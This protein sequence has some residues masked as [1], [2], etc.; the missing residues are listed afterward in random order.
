LISSCITPVASSISYRGSGR[1]P[2]FFFSA[3]SCWSARRSSRFATPAVSVG[4]RRPHTLRDRAV[5]RYPELD[6]CANVYRSGSA[7]LTGSWADSNWS[8]PY[9][10][11][12]EY[13]IWLRASDSGLIDPK[14][15][16]LTPFDVHWDLYH[17]EKVVSSSL[18]ATLIITSLTAVPTQEPL[19]APS[20]LIPSSPSADLSRLLFSGG[21]RVTGRLG[22]MSRQ[23]LCRG[24]RTNGRAART[25]AR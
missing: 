5:Y 3:S 18:Q 12:G 2:H 6:G 11:R 25:S 1:F 10:P 20:A 17:D 15:I 21:G 13:Q 7:G 14:G 22:G 16:A 23:A 24:N 8:I 9:E 19:P 4:W